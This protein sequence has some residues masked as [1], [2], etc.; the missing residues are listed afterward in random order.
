MADLARFPNAL[1]VIPGPHEE[2]GPGWFGGYRI[3]AYRCIRT[4]R[5]HVIVD[6]GQFWE[7][8]WGL[9]DGERRLTIRKPT[10]V[11]RGEGD[12]LIDALAD[13]RKVEAQEVQA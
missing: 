12:T 2:T 1:P 8:G 5:V 7:P 6:D 13:V 9:P 4:K 11:A 10:V 3:S